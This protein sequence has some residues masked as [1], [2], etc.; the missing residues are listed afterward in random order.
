MATGKLFAIVSF[1]VCFPIIVYILLSML[2]N[3]EYYSKLSGLN[4]DFT[5][6]YLVSYLLII[7]VIATFI[8][9]VFIR[10]R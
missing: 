10:K 5:M 1:A 6:H 7:G 9:T 2:Q 4:E 3:I 8:H